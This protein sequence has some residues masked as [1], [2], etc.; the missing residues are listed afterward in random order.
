MWRSTDLPGVVTTDGC[1]QL[2]RGLRRGLKQG[3]GE[4]GFREAQDLQV[5]D[6]QVIPSA[7]GDEAAI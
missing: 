5:V 7:E 6:F 2:P 4:V 1:I 3:L